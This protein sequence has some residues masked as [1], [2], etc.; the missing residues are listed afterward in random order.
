M[1]GDTSKPLERRRNNGTPTWSQTAANRDRHMV[2]IRRFAA[3]HGLRRRLAGR[4]TSPWPRLPEAWNRIKPSLRAFQRREVKVLGFGVK[5]RLRPQRMALRGYCDPFGLVGANGKACGEAG[6]CCF[7]GTPPV[8]W[9][10]L[11]LLWVLLTG[12]IC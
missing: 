11:P 12:F 4:E 9:G 2:A 5:V 7:S 1:V 8:V 6:V 10:C 3:S